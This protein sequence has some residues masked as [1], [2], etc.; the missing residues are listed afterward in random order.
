MPREHAVPSPRGTL[1]AVEWPAPAESGL[2]P[3]VL[4]HDS[5]GSVALW[6]SFP[7]ALAEHTGRTVIAYDRLGF[8]RSDARLDRL[9][10]AFVEEESRTA[11]AAVH[12][13]LAPG[14]F[15]VMGH[16]VGGGMAVHIAA[17][18]PRDCVALVTESAQAF[19]EDLTL[20]SIA[21]ARDA[22]TDPA[23][24]ERLARYHGD[25]ARWV[26]DAWTGTWL[27]DAFASW[28]LKDVLPQVRC[29]TLVL[30]GEFDEYGTAVHPRTIA[31]GV[32]GPAQQVLLAG[33]QHVP[34]REDEAGIARRV[35]DFLRPLKR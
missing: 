20:R 30:H 16:S 29:P 22:F 13:A 27:S 3:I 31:E 4:L 24:L 17:R 26:L 18:H 28:S 23:Q 7:A 33:A 19:A 6:R 15:V 12:E 10:P 9:T 32:S 2:A 5:L 11:F 34:H 8:G 14:P 35:A 25:K 1:H 21:E